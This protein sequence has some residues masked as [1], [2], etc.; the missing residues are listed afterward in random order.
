MKL[1]RIIITLFKMSDWK[2]KAAEKR[3]Q[4]AASIPEEWRLKEIPSDFVSALDFI[5]SSNLLTSEE[6][7]ITEIT[8]GRVLQ[9]MLTSAE[10]TCVEVI[11]AFSKRAA[12]AQ[13]L[14]GCCTEMF[15]DVAIARAREL[16]AHFQKTGKPVGPLHGFPVSFKDL[17]DVKGVDTTIGTALTRFANVNVSANDKFARLGWPNWEAGQAKQYGC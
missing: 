16:D 17:F 3:R 5:R 7:R 13:Q 2:A 10:V 9:R 12:I 11:T 14:T 8:D 6:L 1:P 4:Q 15:F